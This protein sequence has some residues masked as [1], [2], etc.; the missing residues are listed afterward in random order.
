PGCDDLLAVLLTLLF[1]KRAAQRR[2]GARVAVLG[3]GFGGD[4]S[5]V[6]VFVVIQNPDQSRREFGH[7]QADQATDELGAIFL[8]SPVRFFI[9]KLV[10]AIAHIRVIRQTIHQAGEKFRAIFTGFKET[11]ADAIRWF[12]RRRAGAVRPVC[13]QLLDR[14][15]V[16]GR[17]I[18]LFG[19]VSLRR[20][21]V[22]RLRRLRRGLQ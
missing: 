21:F 18:L 22:G 16:G 1:F 3:Q 11:L 5:D 7:V 20:L 8:H 2:D 15:V 19:R 13:D 17:F 4:G 14:S 12:W 6:R 9:Q 10:Q